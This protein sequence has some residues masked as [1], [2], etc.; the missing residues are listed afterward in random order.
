MLHLFNRG[1]VS[2]PQ[3]WIFME[4]APQCPGIH[5]KIVFGTQILKKLTKGR[6]FLARKQMIVLTLVNILL[7][8]LPA[9]S[10]NEMIF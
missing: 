4:L 10:N 6:S 2:F 1:G 8:R 5:P 7:K 3:L 9:A